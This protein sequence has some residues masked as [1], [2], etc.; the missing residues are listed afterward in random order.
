MSKQGPKS[1]NTTLIIVALAMGLIAVVLNSVYIS[2]VRNQA[3]VDSFVVYRMTRSMLPGDTLKRRDVTEAR[4]PTSFQ[5]AF[6]NT[7]DEQTLDLRIGA[8]LRRPVEQGA[9]LTHDLFT[10]PEDS[11]LDRMITVGK[12]LYPLPVN[13]RMMPG[14]LRP[15]MFVDIEAPFRVSGN[16]AEVLPVME[17]VKVISVGKRDITDEQLDSRGRAKPIGSYHT[18]SIEVEPAEATQLSTIQTLA[19][20]D[21]HL[22]LRNPGDD[23]A[24]K[25]PTGGINPRVL[26]LLPGS[27]PALNL[28]PTSALPSP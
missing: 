18:I 8:E 7:V 3:R 2:M 17:R 12:R 25:I 4:L 11:D 20:G 9:P 21:F 14:S 5:D 10:A 13:A 22:H 28:P 15:G 27:P 6:S 19:T 1:G 24:P 23:T 16:T 26:Q